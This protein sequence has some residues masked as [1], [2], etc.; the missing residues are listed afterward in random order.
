MTTAKKIFW[1]LRKFE[2]E[3]AFNG[4]ANLA[5]IKENGVSIWSIYAHTEKSLRCKVTKWIKANW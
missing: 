4:D 2:V 3:Y 1:N 5:V